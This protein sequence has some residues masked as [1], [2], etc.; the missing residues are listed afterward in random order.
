M[1]PNSDYRYGTNK[2]YVGNI[3]TVSN[4]TK[5]FK[6]R[7]SLT[8]NEWSH[9]QLLYP[10]ISISVESPLQPAVPIHKLLL[11]A[12]NFIAM[13]T[14]FTSRKLIFPVKKCTGIFQH[15]ISEKK[16]ESIRA[17]RVFSLSGLLVIVT[18]FKYFGYIR[19]LSRALSGFVSGDSELETTATYSGA[20]LMKQCPIFVVWSVFDS[21]ASVRSKEAWSPWPRVAT[22]RTK[23]PIFVRRTK[24]SPLFLQLGPP[25]ARYFDLLFLKISRGYW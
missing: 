2:I 17:A 5:P 3:R 14:A 12:H 16:L 18:T 6:K 24:L 19:P 13:Y 23:P 8:P 21:D 1:S 22:A 11:W 20:L 15:F 4:G 25:T 10:Y 7:P 9:G